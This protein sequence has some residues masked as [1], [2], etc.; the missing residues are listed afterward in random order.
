MK[1]LKNLVKAEWSP[2]LDDKKQTYDNGVITCPN[3]G[4]LHLK[5][6]ETNVELCKTCYKRHNRSHFPTG[7]KLHD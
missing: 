6:E 2:Y 4:Q 1:N 5:N 7:R 3:C